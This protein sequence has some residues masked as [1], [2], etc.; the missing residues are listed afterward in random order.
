MLRNCRNKL[1][2]LDDILA[3]SK[4]TIA[5]HEKEIEKILF[6]WTKKT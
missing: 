3:I 2:F 6:Y 5:E 4:S 1:A